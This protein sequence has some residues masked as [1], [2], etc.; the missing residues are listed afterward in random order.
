MEESIKENKITEGEEH[1]EDL[2]NENNENI[3]SKKSKKKKKK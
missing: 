3:E 1:P 2:L